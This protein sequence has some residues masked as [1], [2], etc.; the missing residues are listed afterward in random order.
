MSDKSCCFVDV[1][2]FQCDNTFIL[3]ELALQNLHGTVQEH[4]LFKPPFEFCELSQK[5]QITNSWLTRKNHCLDWY[6]GEIKY[7]RFTLVLERIA[8]TYSCIYVKGK[9]KRDWLLDYV[10]RHCKIINLENLGCPPLLDLSFIPTISCCL[11]H[12]SCA[13]SIA[14]RLRTWYIS[15]DTTTGGSF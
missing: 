7:N 10:P 4:F 15:N 12:P 1:Q 2:G 11:N 14:S 13:L 5:D 8:R 3:K 9:M 6:C